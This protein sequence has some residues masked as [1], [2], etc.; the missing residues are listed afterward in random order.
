MYMIAFASLIKKEKF[1]AD[2]MAQWVKVPVTTSGS[3]NFS[4]DSHG[5]RREWA[6]AC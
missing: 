6:P 4:W 2:G 5:D 1:Q 3:L